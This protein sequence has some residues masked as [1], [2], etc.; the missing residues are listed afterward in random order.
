MLA[1]LPGASE[2]AEFTR[3]FDWSRT[4]LGPIDH[5]PSSLKTTVSALLNSRHPMFLWWGPELIQ[6]YN[7]GFIPLLGRDR[8]Q[9]ALGAKGRRFW[10]ERAWSIMEPQ[11]E[12]VVQRGE[13]TWNRDQRIPIQ[14]NGRLEEAFWTSSYSPVWDEN[15]DIC[16][17]LLVV[18]ETTEYVLN[19]RR[20]QTL[21]DLAAL[22]LLERDIHDTARSAIET[23]DR[24][25]ADIPFS[26]CYLLDADRTHGSLT[27]VAGLVE[28][29]ASAPRWIPIEPES[30]STLRMQTIW[31]IAEAITQRR[32]LTVNNV[33]QRYGV[34]P[35]EERWPE[36]ANSA[37][38]FPIL[39]SEEG[40]PLGALILGVSAHLPFDTAYRTYLD[41]V[42]HQVGV[43]TTKASAEYSRAQLLVAE[44]FARAER[45]QLLSE[46]NAARLRA[47]AAEARLV[48][49]FQQSP[50]FLCILRGPH[51]VFELAN[52]TF[53]N[54]IGHRDII[55]KSLEE[56]LPELEGQGFRE[57]ADEVIR[58]G[59]RYVGR[60]VRAMLE[61]TAGAPL[62]ERFFDFNYQPL[63]EPDGSISGIV[64]HGTDVTEQ[65]LARRHVERLLRES[66]EARRALEAAHAAAENAR[67]EAVEANRAKAEFLAVMSHE[68]RTPL[69][70]IAG[71]TQV[72][73]MEV[74]G[75][76]T[77]AM[78]EDLARI[79]R[80]QAH[81]TGL[82]NS[83]LNYAK[84]EAGNV[85]YT[86]TEISLPQ[87]ITEVEVLVAPEIRRKS[88]ILELALG[89][90]PLLVIADAE[91]VR[92][93]LLNLLTNAT[94]FTPPDGHITVS[95]EPIRGSKMA[96]VRVADTGIGI[97]PQQLR[98]IFDPFVQVGRGLT[99]TNDGVGLGLSISHELARGMKGDLRVQSVVGEGTTFTLTL[100]RVIASTGKN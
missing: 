35:H 54:V 79:Q 12:A 60:E 58:T 17:V 30:S 45:D 77:K 74:H 21:Y 64:V 2:M 67:E 13:S 37:L 70:A 95:C 33:M 65:V 93:I 7:D 80:N 98:R 90:E 3:T 15:G 28:G 18:Q 100:P 20:L 10:P 51:H 99:S 11:I 78:Q 53:Y 48:E 25:W 55:G 38:V 85:E 8:Y 61:R 27:G 96:A 68:L 56:A 59:K 22:T 39:P 81:L 14:R 66:E 84:L 44:R 83:V 9:E 63:T 49:V 32:T 19:Q 91:K 52:E 50:M 24:N 26:L 5:W 62:E 41:S 40:C 71:Y 16:G 31:P 57:I 87:I 94:K 75:P 69:N 43:V 97:E 92:Q 36:S 46:A 73:Q 72:L 47:E 4:P 86:L 6:F 76:V 23:I 82:I 42:A 34:P 88:L 1:P 29:S 89:N